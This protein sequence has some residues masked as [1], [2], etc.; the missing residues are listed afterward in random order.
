MSATPNLGSD[1]AAAR[2]HR[3]LVADRDETE[4]AVLADL[5]IRA[6]FLVDVTCD[7]SSVMAAL[8]ARAPDVLLVDVDLPGHGGRLGERRQANPIQRDAETLRQ[9]GRG[10]CLIAERT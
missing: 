9:T 7:G 2:R 5:L 4:G 8:D 1:R 10:R 3:V 6:G